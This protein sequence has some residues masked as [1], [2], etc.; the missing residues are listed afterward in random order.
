MWIVLE[1]YDVV[2]LI[3]CIELMIVNMEYLGVLNEVD[4]IKVL[5]G[6][7]FVVQ[8]IC[9]F[10]EFIDMIMF[11]ILENWLVDMMVVF[12]FVKL[13]DMQKVFSNVVVCYGY[14]Q[15]INKVLGDFEFF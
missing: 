15:L 9:G 8:K 2:Y 7:D 4:W 11:G 10:V 6:I 3:E 13:V 5:Q 1:F 14:L 12:S